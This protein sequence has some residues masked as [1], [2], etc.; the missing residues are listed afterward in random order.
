[1]GKPFKEFM[2]E[3]RTVDRWFVVKVAMGGAFMGALL[4]V[5]YMLF[6]LTV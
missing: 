2:A 1:M 5:A 3:T 4:A 6:G